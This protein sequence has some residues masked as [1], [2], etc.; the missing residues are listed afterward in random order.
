[1]AEQF[2]FFS[3]GD[4]AEDGGDLVSARRAFER[5][6]ALGDDN[7]WL[8]LGLL[9]DLGKGCE[10]NKVEA[11][12][13]YRRAWRRRNIAAANNIAILYREKGDRRLMFRW[14]ERAA[15]EG[16]GGAYVELAKC[17]RDGVGVRR[18]PDAAVRCLAAASSCEFISEAEREEATAVR[19]A[20]RPRLA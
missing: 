16:D 1:M 17:Y 4:A 2:P 9:H 7:C 18:S 8:R 5:G 13:C 11:M 15:S 3:A 6:A 19:V 10:T 20:F 12:R 14:F